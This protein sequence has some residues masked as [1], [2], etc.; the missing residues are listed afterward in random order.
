VRY[1]FAQEVTLYHREQVTDHQE[2]GEKGGWTVTP[3][4]RRGHW[5]AQRAGHPDLIG[6][7]PHGVVAAQAVGQR[8]RHPRLVAHLDRHRHVG[9]AQALG[10][11]GQPAVVVK[12]VAGAPVG[13]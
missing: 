3:H 6:Q 4:W 13:W 11:V 9:V 10:S 1:A 8:R 7:H 12:T 5:R 2:V